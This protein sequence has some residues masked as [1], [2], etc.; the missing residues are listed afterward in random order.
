MRKKIT[1]FVCVLA[2]FASIPLFAAE[3]PQPWHE[4]N[5]S[6]V[7]YPPQVRNFFD[8][9]AAMNTEDAKRVAVPALSGAGGG[10]GTVPAGHGSDA[11]GGLW[12][13]TTTQEIL[14]YFAAL[15]TAYMRTGIVGSFPDYNEDRT[16]NNEWHDMLLAVFSKDG[17]VFAPDEVKA[18]GKPVVYIQ[19][20]IHGNEPSGTDGALEL[21]RRVA[22]GEFN[23]V[24]EHV[25]LV[26]LPRWNLDGAKHIIR[27]TNLLAGRPGSEMGF[28]QNRDHI[29]MQSY[30]SM[31]V[32]RVALDYRPVAA[33]DMH[34]MGFSNGS[35]M[36]GN[37]P[38]WYY[39]LHD[40]AT[41]PG[42]NP[43]IPFRV[44]QFA[45]DVFM[46]NFE[47]DLN[48]KGIYWH[49]YDENVA[50]ENIAKTEALSNDM[51]TVYPVSANATRK[52][53]M[54][55]G[56]NDEG[57]GRPN[58]GFIPASSF[59]AETRSPAAFTSYLRRVYT[60]Y[61]TAASLLR[62]AAIHADELVDQQA[63]ASD[64][65]INA[66]ELILRLRFPGV[67]EKWPVAEWN[68]DFTALV[69]TSYD[70]IMYRSRYAYPDST[71]PYSVVTKPT[72][73][74]IP[75][76]YAMRNV[77]G[78][79][80]INGVKF[81]RLAEDVS[82]P[83]ETYRIDRIAANSST[84]PG[85]VGFKLLDPTAV[86]SPNYIRNK[87]ISAVSTGISAVTARTENVSLPKG[88]F[89]L[90]TDQV[91]ATAA[92]LGIEPMGQRNFANY[93]LTQVS[94]S[95]DKLAY[96]EDEGFF[97]VAAGEDYPVLR[98]LGDKSDLPTYSM[99]SE[100]PPFIEDSPLVGIGTITDTELNDAS[101][102]LAK[103]G[104]PVYAVKLRVLSERKNSDGH[105]TL[106]PVKF[107]PAKYD[108][109]LKRS[110]GDW[111]PAAISGGKI[112]VAS[113]YLTPGGYLDYYREAFLV[114][115]DN[116][117][118]PPY[119]DTYPFDPSLSDL[120]I[121]QSGSAFR[122]IIDNSSLV[123]GERVRL[124]FLWSDSGVRKEA[125]T[126]VTVTAQADGTFAT[127]S[128]PYNNID[129]SGAAIQF[130]EVYTIEYEGISSGATGYAA[131]GFSFSGNSGGGGGGG[132]DA[133]FGAFALLLSTG[134]IAV[135]RRKD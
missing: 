63:K 9:V 98:Y 41:L 31:T 56:T 4:T 99:P 92:A 107:D 120:T 35:R 78:K 122:A 48:N 65:M 20:T 109:F 12:K 68:S 102:E 111:E 40:I 121:E 96:C 24:L 8:N 105:I 93:Y 60:H 125:F 6:L 38:Y 51:V 30:A 101:R 87:T 97:R 88:T 116:V 114:A 110:G 135:L 115:Y 67:V 112:V 44:R 104:E 100:R 66:N 33:L 47:R 134:A 36:P 129:G 127:A 22:G 79:M 50:N 86:G 54:S 123:D 1:F 103:A 108:Y 76:T 58:F 70:A 117:P 132:C 23:D 73:Y 49:Y 91:A 2:L 17:N 43:N 130:G 10:A 52:Y 32:H 57:I 89:V 106:N 119:S 75:D 62:T 69:P 19:G 39:Q 46:K 61:L 42:Q 27:G 77:V 81:D 71:I 45:Y 5:E 16:F 131:P 124:W 7:V 53:Q 55:E 28:D 133:G 85:R 95:A 94:A 72:A 83:V 13:Y 26:L 29:V 21:A 15:P 90:Y 25:T 18:L 37:G 82:I 11:P 80:I 34:E 59:L 64:E 128:I 84:D 74:I 3:P 14:D 126:D 118:T 113:D